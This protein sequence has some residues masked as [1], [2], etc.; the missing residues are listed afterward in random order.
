[1]DLQLAYSRM[2]KP[3]HLQYQ[4]ALHLELLIYQRVIHAPARQHGI[5]QRKIKCVMSNLFNGF[6][7]LNMYNTVK[8]V[9]LGY[10]IVEK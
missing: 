1:M 8:E 4:S 5:I 7:S 6:I 10:K 3:N 9:I 2:M